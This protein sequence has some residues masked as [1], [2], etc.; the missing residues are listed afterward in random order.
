MEL[1]KEQ[2]ITHSGRVEA[3]MPEMELPK[4]Q[5]NA[6]SGWVKGKMYIGKCKIQTY[7]L[8]SAICIL[9]FSI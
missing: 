2:R 1:P 8:L 3:C 7:N 6:Q 5:L 4:E 9:L